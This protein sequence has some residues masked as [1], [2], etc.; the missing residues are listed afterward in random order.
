MSCSK[1]ADERTCV[2]QDVNSNHIKDVRAEEISVK[3]WNEI[4]E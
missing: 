1:I 3:L 2:T 4:N